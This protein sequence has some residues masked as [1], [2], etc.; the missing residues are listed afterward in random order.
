MNTNTTE[1]KESDA[2]KQKTGGGWM[3]RL[4]R[5]CEMLGIDG[6]CKLEEP[7][8]A[9][10][11]AETTQP[12]KEPDAPKWVEEWGEFME[13]NPLGTE[14]EYLGIRMTVVNMS[15]A[16]YHESKYYVGWIEGELECEYVDNHG[17]IQRKCFTGV[18]ALQCLPNDQVEARRDKTPPRQ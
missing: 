3:R 8:E 15:P 4:V 5:L 11:L 18:F 10:I 16:R 14:I 1:T 12:P 7:S 6:G 13:S 9:F 2:A 17:I